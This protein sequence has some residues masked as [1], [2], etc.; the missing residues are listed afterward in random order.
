MM[1]LY[2]TIP[3]TAYNIICK[4]DKKRK[5]IIAMRISRGPQPTK[6]Y[7]MCMSKIDTKYTPYNYCRFGLTR[8]IN[9]GTSYI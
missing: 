9:D 8:K 7:N 4:S 3:A 6:R 2:D 1:S 5:N